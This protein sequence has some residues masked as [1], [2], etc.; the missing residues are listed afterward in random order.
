MAELQNAKIWVVIPAFNDCDPLSN[1][2][3]KLAPLGYS[4]VVV[5]DGSSDPIA[6]KL[7]AP[8][9]HVL[10]HCVN[11][12]QG[13]AIATGLRYAIGQGAEYLVTFDA[14]GQHSTEEIST[15]VSPLLDGKTDVTLGT[16]FAPGGNA[17]NISHA[18]RMTLRIATIFSRYTTGL[19]ITDTHNGFRGFTRLAASKIQ[20][21]QNRMAHASQILDEISRLSLSYTEVPVTIRYTAY[22]IAKGQRFSNA[23]NILWESL[24]GKFS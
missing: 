11:L 18:R 10:R 16:R 8:G 5:D 9:V 21:T 12:G 14:D 3:V 1:L 2:L 4:T 23:F 6:S 17:F 24:T 22:S 13:A 20:I 15:I 7:T 19:R